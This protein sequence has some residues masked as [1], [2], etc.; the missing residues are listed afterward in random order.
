MSDIDD[1]VV[2]FLNVLDSLNKMRDPKPPE[3]LRNLNPNQVHMLF[4]IR[5]KPD[6]TQK[7]IAERLKITPA[8]VSTVPGPK[9]LTRSILAQ[10]SPCKRIAC[11]TMP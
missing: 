7:D 9:P 2:R 3:A 5:Y 6:I 8:A 1:L 10:R 11:K 4:S